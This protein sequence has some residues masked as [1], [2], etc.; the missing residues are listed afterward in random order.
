MITSVAPFILGIAGGTGSGKTALSIELR[1]KYFQVGICLIEQDSYYL[2][3]SHLSAMERTGINYDEPQA[4]DHDLLL[5]HLAALSAGRPIEKPVYC[6]ETHTR[7]KETEVVNSAPLILIEGLFA[8]WDPRIR[9]LM[10]FR[11][12]VEADPDIRFIRRC[13]RDVLERGR[14]M[15]SVIDQYL[16]SVR[17]MHYLYIEPTKASAD[18][19]IHNNGDMR[20][21]VSPSEEAIARVFE[22]RKRIRRT[23]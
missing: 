3:R 9:S 4:I 7:K 14:T 21:L 1:Q 20:D 18:L 22:E 11:I 5:Q 23:D 19:V 10:D 12:F 17:P 6:F 15:D 13:R 8:L 2:D 16:N